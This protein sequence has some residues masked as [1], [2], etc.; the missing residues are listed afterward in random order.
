MK[1]KL[2]LDNIIKLNNNMNFESMSK[3]EIKAFCSENEIEIPETVTKKSHYINYLTENFDF[4]EEE[5]IIEIEE[6]V[7][8]EEEEDVPEEEEDVPEEAD[9]DEIEVVEEEVE[10]PTE[11]VL[12]FE[13]EEEDDAVAEDILNISS[14]ESTREQSPEPELVV[15]DTIEEDIEEVEEVEEEDDVV[16]LNMTNDEEGEDEL[17]EEVEVCEIDDDDDDEEVD[18]QSDIVEHRPFVSRAMLMV[19]LQTIMDNMKL[20]YTPELVEEEV[21]TFS[22]NDDGKRTTYSDMNVQTDNKEYV[23]QETQVQ[24]EVCEVEVQT[25]NKKMKDTQSQ[26]ITKKFCE[27]Q[28]QTDTVVETTPVI[29]AQTPVP[30]PVTEVRPKKAKKVKACSIKKCNNPRE[31]KSKFCSECNQ[32]IRDGKIKIKSKK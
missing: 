15:E 18:E 17:I 25:D 5:E 1:I 7:E 21:H 14:V 16:E 4:E 22:I 24:P 3:K 8:V 23:D 28:V 30:E 20:L 9:T 12:D 19:Q 29:T 2:N 11:L 26:T 6:D 32:K 10:E 13:E 27:I 31:T